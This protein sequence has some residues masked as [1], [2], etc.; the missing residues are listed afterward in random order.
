M[1]K[2]ENEMNKPE[3]T[4]KKNSIITNYFIIPK[5]SQKENGKLTLEDNYMYFIRK[6]L[7]PKDNSKMLQHICKDMGLTYTVCLGVF[8]NELVSKSYTEA[9]CKY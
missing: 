4:D 9:Y 6:D 3:N 7:E 1:N 2:P 5:I 8:L